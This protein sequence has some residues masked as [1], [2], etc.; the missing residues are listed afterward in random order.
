MEHLSTR[1]GIMNCWLKYVGSVIIEPFS[2]A[3]TALVSESRHGKSVD[4]TN[5]LYTQMMM[6]I[7][8]IK[9]KKLEIGVS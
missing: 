5:V 3:V 2:L 7:E 6:V 9:R 4:V 8:N 1:L